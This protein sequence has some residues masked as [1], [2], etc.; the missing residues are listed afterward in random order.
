MRGREWYKVQVLKSLR[1][2]NLYDLEV[3][4][5]RKALKRLAPT[6]SVR[7]GRGT[8]YAWIDIRGSGELGD[9]TEREKRALEVF[10]LPYGSNFASISPEERRYYVEK[11]VKLLGISMPKEL[12][13]EY[14]RIDEMK[15]EMERRERE[16]RKRIESCQ[17]EFVKLPY[18]VFPRGTAYRCVKCGY[19]KVELE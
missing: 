9:F 15:K 8:G 17:H 2:K 6:L 18:I 11:A 13:E 12:E 16:R 7:R 10:G 5:I 1:P 3:K 4:L 19:E 14:R